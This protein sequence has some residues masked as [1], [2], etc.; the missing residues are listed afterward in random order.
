MQVEHEAEMKRCFETV[1][2]QRKI[3]E[4]WYII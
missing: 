1:I 4:I 3:S 2:F